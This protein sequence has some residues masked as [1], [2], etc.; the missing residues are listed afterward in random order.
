MVELDALQR[1]PVKIFELERW[2]PA[3]SSAMERRKK[4]GASSSI[5]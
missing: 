2:L 5:S 3:L 4:S 1:R